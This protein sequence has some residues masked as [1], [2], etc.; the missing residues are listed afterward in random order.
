MRMNTK[1]YRIR[2]ICSIKSGKRL[3]AGFDFSAEPTE[4]RYI[5]A[6]DIKAGKI[7]L[8]DVAY[9]DEVTKK[10]IGKYIINAGDV[11][12]TI[13][14]N[15]G[16]IG[17]ATS[18]CDGVNLTENA[19]RLTAFDE[20]VV[21]SKYLA[22]YLGQPSM[23]LYM[24]NLAA[25]AAQAKLDIYKIEK[26]KIQIPNVSIQKSIVDVVEKYDNLIEVNNKRIKVLEQMAENLYKEWFVRF[27]FPGYET[28]EFENGIP[29]G[30]EI[31]KIG[32]ISSI[33][34]GG[35]RPPVFSDSPIEGIS[36]PIFSNGIENEGLYGY[37]DKPLVKSD[38]V[39]ISAR[40]TVGYV[41]LRRVP[42]VPIVR[43]VAIVPDK[44][45]VSSLYLYYYLQRDNVIANGTS[46][47]QITVPMVIRK[48]IIVPPL[49]II[50]QFGRIE[51]PIWDAMDELK[52]ENDNL[53][54][55]RDL[56]LPRLM[57][58][59]LEVK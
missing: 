59:K 36:I 10:R 33:K 14:A 47:Q 18:D 45:V 27:R 51:S 21:F 22:Y 5:R 23:K 3:P 32:E 4:F 44:T 50:D 42:Y 31:R 38:S 13:V 1:T 40:G 16:D 17:Y 30:W 15:I 52:K 7:N 54:K 48:R 11:A 43:L 39:T 37:T 6:R 19:V 58:G 55:Q 2:D 53:I 25:G 46:Q 26:I 57:S 8:D 20:S 29:K 34:A 41:F 35:D 9:I 12:I 56:L 28:A 49:A 24:E